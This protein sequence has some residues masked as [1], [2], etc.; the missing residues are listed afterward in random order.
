MDFLR[1]TV[2]HIVSDCSNYA[3]DRRALVL[4][5]PA[6]MMKG[7]KQMNPTWKYFPERG[8]W[9]APTTKDD[10]FSPHNHSWTAGVL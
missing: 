1:A 7:T 6:R 2:I 9:K 5:P 3:D 10:K 4:E 8:Y